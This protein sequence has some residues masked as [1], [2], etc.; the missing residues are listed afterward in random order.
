MGR[1]I[2]Q[3]IWVVALTALA[4]PALG[5]VDGSDDSRGLELPL[6]TVEAV[7]MG[8]NVY[9][10]ARSGGDYVTGLVGVSLGGISLVLSDRDQSVHAGAL[11]GVGVASIALGVLSV[12]R[13]LLP[14]GGD[15][16]L[17]EKVQVLPHLGSTRTARRAPGLQLRVSF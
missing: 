9:E 1:R 2:T 15:N 5:T 4:N 11:A 3:L 7:F 17:S 14:L 10:I 8:V 13:R 16:L 6:I 12:A